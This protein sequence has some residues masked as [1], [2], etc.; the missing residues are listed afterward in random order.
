MVKILSEPIDIEGTFNPEEDRKK[1]INALIEGVAQDR[2]EVDDREERAEFAP[3]PQRAPASSGMGGLGGELAILLG[4]AAGTVIGG[5]DMREFSSVARKDLGSLQ[6]RKREDLK[7]KNKLDLYLAKGKGQNK[8]QKAT[9]LDSKGVARMGSFDPLTGKVTERENDPSVPQRQSIDEYSTKV[10]LRKEATVDVKNMD[11][12]RKEATK[13]EKALSENEVTMKDLAEAH[14]QLGQGTFQ[15]VVAIRK[16][17]TSLE[18]RLTDQDA[19]AY[20]GEI[21]D[22]QKFNVYLGELKSN[23]MNPRLV[24]EA[25]QVLRGLIE[26][27]ERYGGFK[28]DDYIRRIKAEGIKGDIGSRLP[29]QYKTG[30]DTSKVKD[31]AP[32]GK[33]T[34]FSFQNSLD[35][36]KAETEKLKKELG[37]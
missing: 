17:M 16:I 15:N 29:R 21:S 19:S 20:G 37:K 18:K 23:E 26:S 30:V 12:V 24:R 28:K 25:E 3:A 31:V 33:I 27:A 1:R 22:I 34:R 6:E 14:S 5:G 36:I 32:K 35:E 11:Y 9:Y 4:S 13:L 7:A 8:L 10:G 2:N